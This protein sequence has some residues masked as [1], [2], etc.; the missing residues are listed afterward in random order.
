MR[1]IRKY[2]P[3]VCIFI[4]F[5]VFTCF[6]TWPMIFRLNTSVYGEAGDNLGAIW[7]IWWLKN[8]SSFGGTLT[9]SPAIGFPYGAKFPS[10]PMEPL[11]YVCFFILGLML[12]EVLVFNIDIFLSFLLSGITMY[13]LVR[14][15]TKDRKSAFFAGVAYLIAPYHAYHTMTIGGGIAPVQWMPLYILMLIRFSE[16]PCAKRAALLAFSA[17]L[18]AWTSVHYGLFMFIFT[19]FFLAGRYIYKYIKNRRLAP[20]GA[21]A[22]ASTL[23]VNRYTLLLSLIVI[24]AVVLLV[25]PFYSGA[26]IGAGT[27]RR[28]VTTTVPTQ[29]R[30]EEYVQRNAAIPSYYFTPNRGSLLVRLLSG[31]IDNTGTYRYGRSLYVGWSLLAIAIAGFAVYFLRTRKISSESGES[32]RPDGFIWDGNNSAP[33]HAR[34]DEIKALVFG[35]V[36]A[37][38]ASFILSLKPYLFI[39]NVKIPLPSYLFII[40]LPWFRW[41]LR[42]GVVVQLCVI[43]LASIGFSVLLSHFKNNWKKLVFAPV[44]LLMVLEL[45]IVPP[46]MNYNFSHTPQAFKEI[47][48]IKGNTGIAIYPL[49]AQGY[50][51]TNEIM[52]YQRVFKKPMLNGAMDGSDAEAVR[53]TV[54]NPFNPATPAYLKRLK[55]DY[56]VIFEDEFA[57]LKKDKKTLSKIP[58]GFELFKEFKGPARFSNAKIFKV[59]SSPCDI[60]PVYT[61]NIT[62]PVFLP[63]GVAWRVLAENGKIELVNFSSKTL[64]ANIFIPLSN[65]FSARVVKAR[66]GDKEVWKSRIE[67]KSAV[68][69]VLKN[70]TIPPE[71]LVID[72]MVDGELV[73]LSFNELSWFGAR[74]AS[75]LVGDVRIEK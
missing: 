26:I 69:V 74:V 2:L 53:R 24:L 61:G 41:Y 36:I 9:S 48:K 66:I 31:S 63:G 51:F 47:A 3:E 56:A 46:F 30:V 55:I 4:I 50:F 70:I 72:V 60:L 75:L 16:K 62:V 33:H 28:W 73:P 1:R 40:F 37:A 58:D 64:E 54:F 14:H 6:L 25:L 57:E 32:T 67:R 18:V 43:V 29:L 71:G 59:A 15:I 42:M 7:G 20:K 11:Q 19:P 13:F 12:N 68:E 34:A 49:H 27:S 35:F 44:T 23:S 10:I 17:I 45:L 52:F 22:N 38:L 21:G 65:P 5:A 8:H 39:G